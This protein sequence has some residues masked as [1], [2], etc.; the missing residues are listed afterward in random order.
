VLVEVSGLPGAGKTTLSAAV[1][2][3]IP[4]VLLRIDAIEAA[5]WVAGLP[6]EHDETGI[7]AYAVAHAVA[8][9]HLL[10]GL[11][12]VV[13]AVS[14]V[15]VAR[16]GWRSLAAETESAL[17]VVEVVCPDPLEH[18]RRVEQ[19]PNDLPGFRLPTWESVQRTA[20]GYEPRT[21]DRLV[22]DGTADAVDN[23]RRVLELLR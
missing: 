18:R 20:E 23:V 12:V 16:A 15:E 8:R 2:D 6:H 1:A 14:P 5:M 10:R 11:T 3:A 4:V 9:P 22:V 19:R 17:R 21:D 13:D 7:A